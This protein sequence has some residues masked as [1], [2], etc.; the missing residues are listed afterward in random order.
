MT[1]RVV[2][3]P[4]ALALLASYASLTDPV[5]EMRAAAVDAVAWLTGQGVSRVVV[6]GAAPDPVSV[7]HGVTE[8]LSM[9]VARSL[10]ADAGYAGEIIEATQP[11]T[12]LD[13]TDAE[14]LVVADGSAR[15]GEKAPGHLDER[16]FAFDE[17]I[18]SALARA[19]VEVLRDI[20]EVLGA[21]LLAGGV[22]ALRTLGRVVTGRCEAEVVWAGDPYGVQWWVVRWQCVS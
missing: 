21:E 6:L 4:S 5:A 19:D 14:V 2:V 22:P 13:I 12:L 20:D 3:V 8:P 7:A 10:L 15:R 9:R 16:A 11:G 18:G 17:A 1:A